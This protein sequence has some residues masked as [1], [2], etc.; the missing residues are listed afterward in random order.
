MGKSILNDRQAPLQSAQFWATYRKG[1]GLK[2]PN[3]HKDMTTS[4]G[5]SGNANELGDVGVS[6]GKSSLFFL[7]DCHPEIG[8][9]GEGFTFGKAPR[10]LRSPVRFLC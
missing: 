5:K 6:P 10:F 4:S 2:F 7:T 9:S 8:L 1:I 3:Q